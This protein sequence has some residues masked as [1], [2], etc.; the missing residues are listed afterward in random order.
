MGRKGK[1]EDMPTDSLLRVLRGTLIGIQTACGDQQQFTARGLAVLD[2]LAA[3]L[4]ADQRGHAR[5]AYKRR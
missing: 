3:R 5:R 2:I 1:L 4:P